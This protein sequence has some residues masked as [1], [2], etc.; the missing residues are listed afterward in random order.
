MNWSER[1]IAAAADPAYQAAS[2][3]IDKLGALGAATGGGMGIAERTGV[4]ETGIT[5]T[6]WASIMAIS[7]SAMWL[8]KLT[9]DIVISIQKWRLEKRKLEG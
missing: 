7:V 2:K 5:L 4:I 3:V 9:I 8:V 6:E 1:L